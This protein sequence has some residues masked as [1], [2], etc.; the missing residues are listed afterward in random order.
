MMGKKSFKAAAVKVLKR[1]VAIFHH[2][3]INYDMRYISSA[4]FSYCIRKRH[5]VKM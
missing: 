3:H 5:G 4:F 2:V 1:G